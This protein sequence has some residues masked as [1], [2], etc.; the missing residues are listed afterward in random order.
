MKTKRTFGA[1]SA[2]L[3]VAGMGLFAAT[4]AFAVDSRTGYIECNPNRS[5]AVSSTTTTAGSPTSTFAV[6]HYVG[7]GGTVSWSTAGYHSSA[8]GT[9]GGNWTISTTG[10][11]RSGGASCA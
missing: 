11:V 1:F 6:G 4:P 2:G 9:S 10:T 3:L 8:H 5:V 7:G